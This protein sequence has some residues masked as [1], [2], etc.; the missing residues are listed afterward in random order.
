MTPIRRVALFDSLSWN[1]RMDAGEYAVHYSSFPA[2]HAGAAYCDVF[3]SLADAEAYANAYTTAQA[4]VRCR[5]YDVQGIVG[6]PVF[7]VAGTAYKGESDMSK[8]R[9]WVG[10]VLFVGGSTLFA[11]DVV[12]DYRLLWPSTIGCRMLVPGALLLV[13]EG[14]V[15]LTARQTMRR[16]MAAL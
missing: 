7:E 14:L 10:G 8:F 2:E 13:T 12:E 11:V 4:D 6:P 15:V 9:R 1:Q 5:V 16:K 3:P